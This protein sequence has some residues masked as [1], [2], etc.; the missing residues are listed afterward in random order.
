MTIKDEEQL[1]WDIK[2]RKWRTAFKNNI[3]CTDIEI[4][5]D[6]DIFIYFDYGVNSVTTTIDELAEVVRLAKIFRDRRV[7]YKGKEVKKL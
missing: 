6:G 5:D 1:P 2:S 4:Y 3:G 7:A